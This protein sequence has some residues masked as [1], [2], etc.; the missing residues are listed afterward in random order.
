MN[1]SHLFVAAVLCL[2]AASFAEDAAHSPGW[3]VIP[4]NEY[5]ALHAKAYPAPREADPPPVEA[6]LTR[7]DYDLRVDGLLA[8]GRATL[9]I[10]VLKDGWVR[11]PLPT[12]RRASRIDPLAALRQEQDKVADKYERAAMK[13]QPGGGLHRDFDDSRTSNWR[14]TQYA[15]R[16]PAF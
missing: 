8:T 5:Q 2:A 3:V 4:V 14:M 15:Y 11:V 10:D 7:V 1:R 9:T 16:I 13:G 6:T 12:A